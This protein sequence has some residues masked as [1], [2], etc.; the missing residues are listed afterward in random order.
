MENYPAC[1]QGF[2]TLK[3]VGL[4]FGRVFWSMP[5]QSAIFYYRKTGFI[6]ESG[7]P[8]TCL[9][10]TATIEPGLASPDVVQSLC[11]QF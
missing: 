4:I 8:K 7:L 10:C 2:F 6:A 3:L 5:I 11:G 1:H 9:W